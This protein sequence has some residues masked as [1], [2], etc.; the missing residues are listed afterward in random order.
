M[1]VR[2]PE[3]LPLQTRLAP[4]GA[5]DADAR[6]IEVVWTTGATV[7]RQRWTG[8]DTAVP[9]DE[10]LVVSEEAVDL[11]RLQAG[12]PVLDSHS[13]W[14][15]ESQRGVVERAWLAA[16]EG[17]AL[18]RFPTPGTDERSDRLLALAQQKIV[19]NISVGYFI[20]QVRVVSPQKAGEIERRVIERWQPYELSFVTV[21]ADMGAQTRAAD[22][23][24]MPLTV[25]DPAADAVAVRHAADL[26]RAR[27]RMRARQAG[28][29][30]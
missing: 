16:G 25:L 12:A 21:P 5:V 19:R 17:R 13:S 23:L 26:A 11:S 20:T 28:L 8:W 1:T 4:L 18:L 2:R 22:A 27:M 29:R 15:T 10:E 3:G 30:A 24:V 7:R 14:S 6:T 9:F